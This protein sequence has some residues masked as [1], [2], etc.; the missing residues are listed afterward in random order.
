MGS[1]LLATGSILAAFFAGSVA[2]FAPCCIVFL[3]PSYL[4]GAVKNRRWRLL[5]LTFLFA[6]GEAGLV[7]PLRR[8]AKRRG[9]DASIRGYWKRGVE[10]FDD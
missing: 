3:A 8:W 6:A 9:I 1:E 7:K 2:L 10:G 4:A 5:P